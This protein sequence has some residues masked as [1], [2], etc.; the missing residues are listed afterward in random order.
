MKSIKTR[1]VMS[2]TALLL[3]VCA[4]LGILAYITAANAIIQQT[5]ETLPQVAKEGAK[6]VQERVNTLLSTLEAVAEREELTDVNT[7]WEAKKALLE[8]EAERSGHKAM[9]LAG[10]DGSARITTGNEV[11]IKDRDYFIKALSGQRAVSDPLIS[12]DDGTLTVVYAVPVRKDGKVVGVLA[13]LRDGT[14]LSK[15]TSDIT[16]GKSGKAF[17]IN[18]QGVKVAH[19]NL[20]LVTKMDNDFE[21]VKKDATLQP[22]AELEKKMTEG[23]YGAGEY[24]YEGIKKYL[25]FAPVEGT[26]WFLAVAAPKEEVLSGL[27]TLGYSV[28]LASVIFLAAGI[29]LGYFIARLIAAPV[30]KAS[31]HLKVIAAGDFTQA[32]SGEFAARKDEIGVLSRAV[33]TMRSSVQEVIDGVIRESR[34]VTESV[35]ASRQNMSELLSQIEEVSAT[36]EELSAGMQETAASTE[37]MNATALEIEQAVGSIASKA[38][39]GAISA[40]EV[41]NR[42]KSLKTSFQATQQNGMKI[43]NEVSRRLET[44]LEESKAVNQINLLADAILEITSQTNLLALNAAIE[45]AR[46]GEAGKGFAVVAEEIRK[47]AEDSKKTATEIQDITKAVIGSVENLSSNSNSLLVFMTNDVGRDYQSMMNAVEQYEKDAEYM[48][49]LVADFSATSEELAASMENMVKAINEI[50]SAANEGAEG[51][52]S[53]AQKSTVIVEKADEVMRQADH[54]RES[55]DKLIHLVSRFK[56]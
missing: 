7:P 4:G 25:G 21:N 34:N 52:A 53:I 19:S 42:A 14:A 8:R 56:V 2:V 5:R 50:T 24:R 12:R 18:K 20:D 26:D 40:G 13:A 36:T 47:L 1:M 28:L 32:A 31:E 39:E 55:A 43:I 29:L 27:K 30:I 15:I 46:A 9:L 35:K 17:M 38:Q 16:Y 45:A 41:K 54:S 23:G 3:L 44:A 49:D 37:E 48:D 22:L 6:V 33:E 51:T 10:I 11:D